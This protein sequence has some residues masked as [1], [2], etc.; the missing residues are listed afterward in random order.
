VRYT[1]LAKLPAFERSLIKDHHITSQREN[2][3]R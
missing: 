1:K 2:E 3:Q